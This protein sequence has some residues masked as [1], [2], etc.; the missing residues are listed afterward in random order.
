MT[1]GLTFAGIGDFNGDGTDDFA[2]YDTA[3]GAAEF[4]QIDDKQFVA[5]HEIA[6][7]G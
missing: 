5:R 2:W 4:W 1:A 6:L 7:I 3:T